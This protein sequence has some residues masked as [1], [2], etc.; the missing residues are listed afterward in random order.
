MLAYIFKKEQWMSKPNTKNMI[1]Y[2]REGEGG[3]NRYTSFDFRIT[4]D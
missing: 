3:K 2:G 4:I 1:P